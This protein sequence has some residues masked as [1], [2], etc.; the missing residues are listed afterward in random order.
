MATSLSKLI[1]RPVFP[2]PVFMVLLTTGNIRL[3][4]HAS[5]SPLN[6]SVM[7]VPEYPDG[8]RK[9]EIRLNAILIRIQFRSGTVPWRVKTMKILVNHEGSNYGKA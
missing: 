2:F 3:R 5:D 6:T 8:P 7:T 9:V 1:G 4:N